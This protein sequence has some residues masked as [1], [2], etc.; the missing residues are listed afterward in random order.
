MTEFLVSL[1]NN[2][3]RTHIMFTK[4][5]A[6]VSKTVAACAVA[7]ALVLGATLSG[8]ASTASAETAPPAPVLTYTTLPFVVP[9]A[10][11][12]G[13][14]F[15]LAGNITNNAA[16]H[17]GDLRGE[18]RCTDGKRFGVQFIDRGAYGY[19]SVLSEIDVSE[20]ENRCDLSVTTGHAGVYIAFAYGHGAVSYSTLFEFTFVKIEA[21]AII[22]SRNGGL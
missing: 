2:Y 15:A 9:P 21:S 22:V 7:S 12:S 16:L 11:P 1:V 14:K 19:V 18:V 8:G 4:P 10:N 13:E 6:R 3:G 17:E 5:S 20:A